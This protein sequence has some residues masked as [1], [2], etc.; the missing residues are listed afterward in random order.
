LPVN[1]L[2]VEFAYRYTYAG[3]V[4]SGPNY[5]DFTQSPIAVEP[6]TAE[7]KSRLDMH[8]FNV[9]LRYAF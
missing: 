5:T 6:L 1:N 8:Q 3:I 2:S 4:E 9:S 7:I